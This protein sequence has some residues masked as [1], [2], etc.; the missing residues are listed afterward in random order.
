MVVTIPTGTS[1]WCPAWV[2]SASTNTSSFWSRYWN[3]A[4][5]RLVGVTVTMDAVAAAVY[6]VT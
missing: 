2:T 4:L 6:P 5:N 1:T 3:D